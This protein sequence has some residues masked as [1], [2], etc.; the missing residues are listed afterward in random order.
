M[1]RF[2]VVKKS[3][4]G[5]DRLCIQDD[6]NAHLVAVECPQDPEEYED[7]KFG[8]NRVV[9]YINDNCTTEELISVGKAAEILGVSTQTVRNMEKSDKISSMRI[10]EK[11]RR[12]NRKDVESLLKDKNKQVVFVD[13]EDERFNE[14]LNIALDNQH[15][16]NKRSAHDEAFMDFFGKEFYVY[17]MKRL[18]PLMEMFTF[19]VSPMQSYLLYYMYERETDGS[20]TLD[21]KAISMHT[22]VVDA[23]DLS[24]LNGPD[25]KQYKMELYERITDACIRKIYEKIIEQSVLTPL[26]DIKYFSVEAADKGIYA[27][28]IYNVLYNMP[29]E[30][31]DEFFTKHKDIFNLVKEP[32]LPAKTVLFTLSDIKPVNTTMSFALSKPGLKSGVYVTFNVFRTVPVHG[33]ILAG[34]D[35]T[36][37]R[38]TYVFKLTDEE[39]A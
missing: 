25:L 28:R 4:G 6:S 17:F 19:A 38:P 1:S 8:L 9:E 26:A 39:K 16:Y 10:G 24:L 12:F 31:T 32:L 36:V 35:V 11:H 3:V 5:K 15:C 21:S 20:L 23:I 34:M 14:N 33:S 29:E 27:N 22:S 2:M 13:D 18:K 37:T 30:L 7:L